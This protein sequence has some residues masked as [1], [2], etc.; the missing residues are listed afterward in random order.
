MSVSLSVTQELTSST[1]FLHAPPFQSPQPLD[2]LDD[3]AEGSAARP[4]ASM[5]QRKVTRSAQY[6]QACRSC[7]KAKCRCVPRS[8]GDGC[9][10][11][12][13]LKK[14]CQPSDPVRRYISSDK[15]GSDQRI[16]VLE[17][18]LDSLIS[19]LQ[20]QHNLED[21][22]I[23]LQDEIDNLA[24]FSP[25]Q[26]W[27][28]D[29]DNAD[30]SGL[31]E[32]PPTPFGFGLEPESETGSEWRHVRPLNITTLPGQSDDSRTLTTYLDTFTSIFLPNFPIMDL[33]KWWTAEDLRRDRPLLLQAIA[34]VVC[35]VASQRRT[36][37]DDFKRMASDAYFMK[38]TE[39]CQCDKL[40]GS[41]VDLL[42]AILTYA[43]WGWEQAYG[44][45][46][47]SRWMAPAISLSTRILVRG[48][49]CRPFCPAKQQIR[50]Q[51]GRVQSDGQLSAECR[52]AVL[53]CF[54]LSAV[55]STS[56]VDVECMNWTDHLEDALGVTDA[57][58]Q[59]PQDN[60]LV[61]LVRL[62]LLSLDAIRLRGHVSHRPSQNT[63]S[64]TPP[65]AKVD[66]EELRQ[67]FK[68]LYVAADEILKQQGNHQCMTMRAHICYL[69][70]QLGEAMKPSYPQ[71]LDSQSTG[72]SSQMPSDLG[73]H[74]V[75]AESG[76][77]SDTEILRQPELAIG[78]CITHML[79]I[80]PDKFQGIAFM[81]W[82]QL[83]GSLM[84]L[85]SLIDSNNHGTTAHL[86]PIT[87]DLL[88]LLQRVIQRLTVSSEDL[89]LAQ[90]TAF[91][92]LAS[93]VKALLSR[94][95][96]A[97]ENE[98]VRIP[99]NSQNIATRFRPSQGPFQSPQFWIDRI[100]M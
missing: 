37:S 93:H 67:R 33:S 89:H 15:Q 31:I 11:C 48:K 43:S 85:K 39:S 86:V 95:F 38:T 51:P 76:T 32:E 97:G 98:D 79:E 7:T 17:D 64:W 90:K 4:R 28:G 6:G 84:A 46:S 18:K 20:V 63:P 53:G 35:P 66:A 44:C 60:H 71:Y 27:S 49:G 22:G 77:N 78:S 34:C 16:L 23:L 8:D 3:T 68:R 47:L 69:E 2:G 61:L 19:H 25:G 10:R 1:S 40:Q 30:V 100:F 81:Q 80:P 56:Q 88:Q 94:V 5:K 50:A 73:I 62:Q 92:V 55:A 26:N 29:G 96:V 82:E 9:E 42:L 12:R 45:A 72:V 83:E 99:G 59:C 14:T 87:P 91:T 21:N 75:N 70:L 41:T 52:R 13:R 24:P 57:H 54:A 74:G 58:K 65:V 36:F